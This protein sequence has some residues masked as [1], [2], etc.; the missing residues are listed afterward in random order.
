MDNKDSVNS[1]NGFDPLREVWLGDCY[2]AEF[3]KHMNPTVRSAFERITE[4]TKEDLD[5]IETTLTKL[6]VQVQRPEFTDNIEDYSEN[7]T[8]LKPP[9]MPRDTN[10]TLGNKFYHLRNNYQVDPWQKQLDKMHSNDT[11]VVDTTPETN[12]LAPPSVVRCGRDLYVDYDTHSHVWPIVSGVFTD[13]ARDYRVHIIETDGHS[14]GVFCPVSPGIIVASCWMEEYSKTFPGWEVFQLPREEVQHFG[15]WWIND[16]TVV[17][18][19]QF[20]N[21]IN[22]YAIDWIGDFTETQFS[23]NMLVVDHNTVVS[24]NENYELNEF[25]DSKGINVIVAP[26]RTKSF[27]DGGLHCL[28]V[29]V[30]RDSTKNDFFP[31]RGLNNYLDWM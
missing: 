17:N 7:G 29:D 26:F 20:A 30:V 25:L 31:Q 23:V 22:Q 21:H 5:V 15:K 18:N 12:C 6:G 19:T 3:Y 24:V 1:F 16:T 9:I 11:I 4:M 10:L 28:T 27:W 8:L 2:P 14:D 13:W